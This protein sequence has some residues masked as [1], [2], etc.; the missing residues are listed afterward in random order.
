MLVWDE[1]RTCFEQLLCSRNDF[2]EFIYSRTELLLKI[3]DTAMVLVG[4][5]IVAAGRH[6]RGR[7]SLWSISPLSHE[8]LL[9][10]LPMRR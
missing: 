10:R 5:I 6:T 4:E 3:A 8:M 9:S 1:Q 2:G 7:G